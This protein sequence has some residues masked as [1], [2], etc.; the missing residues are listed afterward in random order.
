[1]SS[2][3]KAA[4]KRLQVVDPMAGSARVYTHS[5]PTAPTKDLHRQDGRVLRKQTLVIERELLRRLRLYCVANDRNLS[6]AV[7]AALEKFLP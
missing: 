3:K 4:A 2:K 5:A 7:A 6:E 1:M